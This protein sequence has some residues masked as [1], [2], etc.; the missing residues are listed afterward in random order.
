[1]A[2]G[3]LPMVTLVKA[4]KSAG[5]RP[6][7]PDSTARAFQ[8][9]IGPD[10]REWLLQITC[11]KAFMLAKLKDR[12]RREAFLI[13]PLSL[14]INHLYITRNG[15]FKSI[16]KVAPS[17]RGEVL[18]FGC[19]S[20]PY[21]T[22]FTNAS[23]YIG[24]D[25]QVSG[26]SH[27]DSK[28]DV[29][30]DGKTIPFPDKKFDAVVCFEVLEHVFNLEEVLAEIRRVLKPGGQLL[31]SIPF[32]W[33]EH[34]VPY[35]FARYTSYGI[36]HLFEKSGFHVVELTK[37]ST[38]VL[39]VCQMFI[40]YIVQYALPRKRFVRRPLL[41]MVILPLNLLSLFVNALLPRR[42]EYFCN[43]VVLSRKVAD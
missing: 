14:V 21:E 39:A 41:L 6:G 37:T 20:K 34:E 12:I 16:S 40:A 10:A 1:M 5:R 19:G 24:V 29:F 27:K 35:D 15:L 38:Y 28:I 9:D 17:I 25:I 22:L 7:E 8:R 31:V 43:S 13:T 11:R 4:V 3:R 23:S 33:D 32:A 18:D 30:Y 2:V 42:Y 36:T 26:H